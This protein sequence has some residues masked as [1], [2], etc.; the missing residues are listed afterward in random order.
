MTAKKIFAGAV[1]L[2]G[3]FLIGDGLFLAMKTNANIGTLLTLGTGAV[4]AV[5]GIWHKK[6]AAFTE[7]GI[8]RGVKYAIV[9]CI[10]AAVSLM[11]FIS[12]VGRSDTVSYD[13]DAVIVLGAAVHGEKVSRSLGFRLNKAAEYAGKN[14]DAL[15][16]VSGGKGPQEKITEAEAMERY[17]IRKGIPQ[18]RIVKEEKAASTYEN[19]KFSRQILDRRLKPG[20]R[21]AYITNRFH[22]YRAGRMGELTGVSARRLGADMDWYAVPSSYL[23]ETLAVVKLWLLKQ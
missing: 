16:V 4:C 19:F 15:I 14:K 17:L 18:S 3:I 12:A 22:L 11:L 9:I 23:R 13:E 6:I 5:Y 2:L 7:R 10:L 21:C 8:M 20:Y 1:F